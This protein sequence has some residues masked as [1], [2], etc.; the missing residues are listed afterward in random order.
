M[1]TKV[2]FAALQYDLKRVNRGDR[3]RRVRVIWDKGWHGGNAAKGH[4]DAEEKLCC[5]CGANDS[6]RHWILGCPHEDCVLIRHEAFGRV[7]ELIE[8]IDRY[9][10][11]AIRMAAVIQD[12]AWNREDGHKIW[13]GLWSAELIERLEAELKFGVMEKTRVEKLQAVALSIGRVLA[14][15]TLELWETKIRKGKRTEIG[16][17]TYTKKLA[18]A[19]LL[20]RA[21]DKKR[22]ASASKD[23]HRKPGQKKSTQEPEAPSETVKLAFRLATWFGRIPANLT[24]NEYAVQYANTPRVERAAGGGGL[25]TALSSNLVRGRL[26]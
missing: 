13:T 8:Q 10:D 20:R 22:R 14:D 16:I 7:T 12:W 2:G 3:A 17:D 23:M 19:A 24:L 5:L 11:D 18:A 26:C 9:D 21:K 1:G 6:E 25:N 15:A 4:C